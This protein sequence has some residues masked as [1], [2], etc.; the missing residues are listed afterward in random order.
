MTTQNPEEHLFSSEYGGTVEMVR[1]LDQTEKDY[2]DACDAFYMTPYKP[3]LEKL[4]DI[5]TEHIN[6]YEISLDAFKEASTIEE[7]AAISSNLLSLQDQRRAEHLNRLLSTDQ[8]TA[9]IGKITL[10]EQPTTTI[11]QAVIKDT[12]N[13]L[14]EYSLTKFQNKVLIHTNLFLKICADE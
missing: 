2:F 14:A 9:I 12:N 7:F 8:F 1:V 10:L 4:H 13:R 5:M 6:A 3:Q 11:P